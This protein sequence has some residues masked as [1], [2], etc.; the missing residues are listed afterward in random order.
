M[1]YDRLR[2]L[3]YPNTDATIC[4]F[5][6]TKSKTKVCYLL[7]HLAI[8][9][10]HPYSDALLLIS[11]DYVGHPCEQALAGNSNRDKWRSHYPG[12]DGR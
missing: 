5:S 7:L 3:S 8:P 10:S 2:P 6:L 12:W 4:V 1:D 11:S 9:D